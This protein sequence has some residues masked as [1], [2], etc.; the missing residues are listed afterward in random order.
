[1]PDGWTWKDENTPVSVGEQKYPAH[2]DVSSY[3]EDYDFSNVDGYYA[4]GEYVERNLTVYVD[5]AYSTLE[6]ATKSLNKEY[7][8]KA[9][10]APEIAKEGSTGDV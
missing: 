6:I 2:F 5:K 1:M 10:E 9:V 8:G 7:D 4:N 3:P